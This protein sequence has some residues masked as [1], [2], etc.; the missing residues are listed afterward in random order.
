MGVPALVV[1]LNKVDM[2]DDPELVELVEME[3]KAM[4][5]LFL[6]LSDFPCFAVRDLLTFYE[7]PGDTI[8][9]VK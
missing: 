3:S 7:Y 2:V 9:I 1:F 4:W 8:A 6:I 5:L